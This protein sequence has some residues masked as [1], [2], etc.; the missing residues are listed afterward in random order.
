MK[1]RIESL[2]RR[3]LE[4]LI[5]PMAFAEIKTQIEK[6]SHEEKVK[7][8]AYLKHLLQAENPAHQAELARRHAEMDAGKKV[9]WQDLKRQ[10]GLS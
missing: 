6:L 4:G 8:M 5:P 9:R 2:R 1:I 10:L 7:V 3:P